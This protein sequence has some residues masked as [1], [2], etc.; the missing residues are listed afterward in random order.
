V[1]RL[2]V[3]LAPVLTAPV[4]VTVPVKVGEASGDLRASASNTAL[5]ATAFALPSMI[6]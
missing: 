4:A 2:A 1:P 3:T 5:P 6:I